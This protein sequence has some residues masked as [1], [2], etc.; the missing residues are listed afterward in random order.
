MSPKLP[1]RPKSLVGLQ[2]RKEK[3]EKDWEELKKRVAKAKTPQE[4]WEMLG[5]I[6]LGEGIFDQGAEEKARRYAEA[7]ASE[8]TKE[9]EMEVCD[10]VLKY[11]LFSLSPRPEKATE[12]AISENLKIPRSRLRKILG[13]LEWAEIIQSVNLGT[14]QPYVVKN[15]G[16]ALAEG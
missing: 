13:L 1:P 10:M 12:K 11:I 6:Y 4:H 2:E 16:K 8:I 5:D 14:I 15:I 9:Q 7:S 3:R